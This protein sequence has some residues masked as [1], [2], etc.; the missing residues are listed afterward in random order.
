LLFN[1]YPVP[2]VFPL[3]TVI[4]AVAYIPHPV[5]LYCQTTLYQDDITRSYRYQIDLVIYSAGYAT[6]GKVYVHNIYLKLKEG[7]SIEYVV[8]TK[9]W[10]GVE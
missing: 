6:I 10:S 7:Y 2:W 4:G 5:I 1:V 8:N 9:R 3:Y